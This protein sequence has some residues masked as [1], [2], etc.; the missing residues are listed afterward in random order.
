MYNQVMTTRLA[1]NLIAMF[2]IFS[3]FIFFP[4]FLP[5]PELDGM[6]DPKTFADSDSQFLNTKGIDIHY[7]SFGEASDTNFVL[8]H[9]YAAHT[10]AWREVTDDFAELGQ[11]VAYDQPGHGLSG[12]PY[13]K[14]PE[15]NPYIPEA[16]VDILNE[17]LNTTGV[18]ETYIVASSTAAQIAL[19][20]AIAYPDKVKGI[21]FA[22]ASVYDAG[23]MRAP[24]RVRRF[25]FSP[26]MDLAGPVIMR[27]QSGDAGLN[28]LKLS[29][30]DESKLTE[31]IIE[32]YRVSQ[33]TSRWNQ[34]LWEVNR[35]SK[36]SGLTPQD[37]AKISLPILVLSGEKDIVVTPEQS[38]QIAKDLGNGTY[39]ELPNCGHLPFEECPD[40]SMNAVKVWLQDFAITPAVN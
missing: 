2:V 31:D 38:L 8:L 9:D 4:F 14:F 27:Q 34:G 35:N 28:L 11:T 18:I 16:Q 33:K 36:A 13:K 39:M 30:A 15:G 26:H 29:W 19:N 3:T 23:A 12:K 24:D 32:G 20:T 21:I 7:K 22:G 5:V 40:L 25:L 1:L 6:V 10:F 17:L 37:L